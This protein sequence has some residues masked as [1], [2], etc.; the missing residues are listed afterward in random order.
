MEQQEVLT[1]AFEKIGAQVDVT[2]RSRLTG[3]AS[4]RAR[5]NAQAVRLDVANR[6]KR[7]EVFDV[8]LNDEDGLG[9]QVSVPD[10]DRKDRHLLLVVKSQGARQGMPQ[11]TE[12]F[13]CGHDERQWFVAGVKNAGVR[14]VRSAKESL[15]PGYA[16]ESQS[17]AKVRKKD[18]NRRKNKGFKRQGEF[19]FV[20]EP[21]F[22]PD[23]KLLLRNEPMQR[24]SAGSKPHM[25]E[26]L[27]RMGGETVH[28]SPAYPNGLTQAS[29]DRLVKENPNARRWAW[30]T[31]RRDATAYVKGKVR[32]S[33]HKTL[34]LK[35]WHRVQISEEETTSSVAFLD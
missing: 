35:E 4:V 8:V 10:I 11:T 3:R 6:G 9:V 1:R 23:E 34:V 7:G 22:K 31:M 26:L 20:P 14:D 30:R 2:P 16:A 25:A 21:S 32:H 15:K 28:V 33:D 29:Y 24:G 27:V 12:K 19:F 13:L 5:Q 17:R 18:R